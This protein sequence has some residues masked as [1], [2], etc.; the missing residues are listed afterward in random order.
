MT[1]RTYY[2][3]N[4]DWRTICEQGRALREAAGTLTGYAAGQH[5]IPT[6]NHAAVV[7]A[8][9]AGMTV[10][11]I[12]SSD[13]LPEPLASIVDYLGD[14]LGPDGREFVPT[15]ELL[16]A[17]EADPKTFARQMGELGCRPAR[18]RVTTEDGEIRQVRGY[19]TAEIRSA[20]DRAVPGG[21]AVPEEDR[22]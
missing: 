19:L 17:L 5:L 21:D 18:D 4:E 14:D 2:M 7:T 11:A 9:G 22:P 16:D 10:D 6:A 8:I 3:P 15:A 12:A 1:V 20:V 13:G